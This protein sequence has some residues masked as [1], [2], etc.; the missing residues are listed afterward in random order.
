MPAEP[1]SVP[2]F[3]VTSDVFERDGLWVVPYKMEL[4]K[5]GTILARGTKFKDMK[6]LKK[7]NAQLMADKVLVW[8]ENAT[9]GWVYLMFG[10]FVP[11]SGSLTPSQDF[12]TFEN[13]YWEP[14]IRRLNITHQLVS[15]NYVSTTV[16]DFI[17]PAYKKLTAMRV[18]QWWTSAPWAQQKLAPFT[19]QAEEVSWDFPKAQGSLVCFHGNISIPALHPRAGQY[20]GKRYPGARYKETNTDTWAIHPIH[21]EQKPIKGRFFREM[22]EA[23]P[24]YDPLSVEEKKTRIF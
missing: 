7:P 17:I 11:P 13:Y 12:Y 21:Q 24:P 3:S 4:L 5:P 18:R 16:D 6:F 8:I 22:W 19:P 9:E 20:N 2:Q 23:I 1:S 15:G 10:T 14:V